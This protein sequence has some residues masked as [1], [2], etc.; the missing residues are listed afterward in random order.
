MQ[1][2]TQALETG[3]SGQ[4]ASKLKPKHNLTVSGRSR[5]QGVDEAEP[6]A[7]PARIRCSAGGGIPRRRIREDGTVERIEEFAT[8]TESDPFADTETPA[9][10]ELLIR[11]A[12]LPVVVIVGG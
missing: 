12:L 4:P 2:L 8:E 11:V 6:A 1:A 5:I 10:A 3:R 7:Q 9:H